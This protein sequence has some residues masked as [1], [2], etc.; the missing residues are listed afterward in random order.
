MGRLVLA[1]AAIV[2]AGGARRGTIVVEGERIVAVDP[3]GDGAGPGSGDQGSETRV[4]LAGR[5]V[6][7]GLVT[8]HFHAA[9]TD[10]GSTTSPFGLAKPVPYQAL[11]AA[12]N[13]ALAL[14]CGYTAAVGAGAGHEMDASLAEAVD[15]GLIRGPRLLPASH[16]IS[17][18]GNSL[19]TAPYW[20]QVGALGASRMA[21]GPDAVTYTV[22]DEIKRGA[23]MIKLYV[24]GGHGLPHPATALE[25]NR[26]EV[27]AAVEAAHDRGVK[28]RAHVVSKPAIM[29][30]IEAGVDVLDHADGM[31]DEVIAACVE[32]GTFVVPSIR[33]TE[34]MLEQVEG[35]RPDVAQRMRSSLDAT[36]EAVAR[37]NEAGVLLTIGDD[38]GSRGLLAHGRY[39]EELV[40][41]TKHVGVTPADLVRWGTR[42]GAAM[43]GRA[44]ELGA[45]EA[46]YLADLL[47]VDGDPLADIAVLADRA[48][49]V[50]VVQGGRVVSGALPGVV[51]I[52]PEE[53]R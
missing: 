35:A 45:V 47:V 41:Y 49:L 20:W 6:L 42:H 4:D 48:H 36:Y 30:T 39:G 24:T 9:Y 13:L 12:R 31:D 11:V 34:I 43:M 3:P 23:R 21:D 28:V 29:M 25:L 46:G 51:G 26:A 14:D 33:L 16:G 52:R 32:R 15:E 17:S 40:S 8:T 18:T 50:A 1:N 10:L 37:A 44:H 53:D 22:R 5:T 38:Y 2:D 19:D 27:T 7:P